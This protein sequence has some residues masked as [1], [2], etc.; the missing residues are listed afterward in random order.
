MPLKSNYLSNF[1]LIFLVAFVAR[2]IYRWQRLRHIPGPTSAAWTI[3]WQ[4]SSALSGRYH[5]RLKEA[6]DTY[7]PLVRIGPNQL[8]SIDPEVLRR[9]SAV[10]SGYTK[11]KFYASGK[12]VPGVDNVVSLRDP[13]KHKEMRALMAPG[14][15]GKANEGFSFEA[16]MD[17]QLLSFISL[18]ERKYVSS[19]SDVR[20]F[21]MAEKTQFFALDAIGDIS[22]GQ[23]F[24]YLEKDQD[25]YQYNE[26]NTTSLPVMNVVSV[27]PSLANLV[28]TWPLRLLLPKEGDQ[29]GFGRLMHFARSYV[30]TRLDPKTPRAHDIMQ[31]HIDNGM[32]KNDLIQQVFLSIIAGSNSSAHALRMTLLSLIT[33]PPAY[34]ALIDEIRRASPP[35]PHVASSRRPRLQDRAPEGDY[36]NGYFVPG[37]TEIGQGFHG[38]GRSKAVWGPDADVFRPERWLAA[39][40]DALRDMTNAVDTHFGYGKY[41]CLGKPIA[42]ME[43]HKAVFELVRRFDFCVVN[44]ETPIKT[45][46]SI[47]LFASDFWVTLTKRNL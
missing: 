22:L 32:T 18:L 6:A 26:I 2:R 40:G 7:G 21:D 10:R 39:Q 37:G 46:A 36:L 43:L 24:G 45:T 13:T 47:F 38:L 3:W 31:A 35:P 5:E 33:S 19:G 44:P 14:F 25:L 15:A 29:V 42:L 27:M 4:L 20:P 30:E 11:G 23:P 41:S 9:M 12:I 16:A 8:L 28:H 1:C 34:S 17:R